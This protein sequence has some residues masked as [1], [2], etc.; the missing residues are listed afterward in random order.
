[1]DGWMKE[2]MGEWVDE[3]I[4]GYIDGRGGLC[5]GSSIRK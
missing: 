2:V 4:D 5:W 1:M 3:K